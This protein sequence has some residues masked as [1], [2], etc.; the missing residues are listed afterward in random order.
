M[1]CIE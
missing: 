1:S